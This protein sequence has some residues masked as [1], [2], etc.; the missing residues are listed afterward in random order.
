MNKAIL[1]LIRFC[2]IMRY[3]GLIF[4]RFYTNLFKI[5][6]VILFDLALSR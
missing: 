5:N 1:Y 2:S 4:T 6:K 3:C